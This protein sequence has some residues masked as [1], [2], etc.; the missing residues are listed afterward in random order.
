[1]RRNLEASGLRIAAFGSFEQSE[2]RIVARIAPDSVLQAILDVGRSEE[3]DAV[4]VSCTNLRTIEIIETAETALGKPVLSSNQALAWH[5][6]R[7]AGLDD[8][9]A[10]LGRLFAQGL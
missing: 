1:M 9:P 5:M 7:L 6:V 10:G 4:F 8:A 3:C 2:E